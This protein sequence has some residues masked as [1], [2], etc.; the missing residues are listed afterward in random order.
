[1]TVSFVGCKAAFTLAGLL[2]VMI[3]LIALGVWI[4]VPH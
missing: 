2:T 1:M 3:A 4:W